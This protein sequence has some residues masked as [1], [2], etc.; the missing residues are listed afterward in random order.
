MIDMNCIIPFEKKL[1][2]TGNIKEIV[3]ISL[4]HEVNQ[5][6]NEVLGN[7][8][9][10]G[11]Y[12][13]HELSVNT[14]DF[15]FV[16]PFSVEL[17]KEVDKDTFEFWIDNFT[18]DVDGNEM[19]IKIDYAISAEE[20]KEEERLDPVDLIVT[21]EE[22]NNDSEG[23]E[24]REDEPEDIVPEK[25]EETREEETEETEV[26]D[27]DQLV[28]SNVEKV[29]TS[30]VISGFETEDDYM[31]FKIHVVKEEE[32][33]ESICQINNIDKDELLKLN[34]IN[35]INVGDK[36]IIPYQNE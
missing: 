18:Y 7:F 15:K 19:T 34:D 28:V 6:N 21:P 9:V 35:D 22:D 16:V 1:K 27:R 8:I 25:E 26:E 2:F 29:N 36:L 13:E 20:V 17:E 23:T 24:D 5:N 33:L 14:E 10:S 4:E 31:T 32:T 30:E 3:S 12:K 11:T